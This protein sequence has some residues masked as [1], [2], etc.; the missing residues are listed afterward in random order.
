MSQRRYRAR[1]L[2][3]SYSRISLHPLRTRTVPSINDSHRDKV[4]AE[5]AKYYQVDDRGYLVLSQW[6]PKE[7]VK[8]LEASGLDST[9]RLNAGGGMISTVLDL[10]KFDVAMDRNLIVYEASKEAMFTS[11][12]SNSGQSCLMD[13]AGSYRNMRGL[14]LSGTMAGRL[15]R[16]HT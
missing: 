3:I 9:P 4:L 1:A 14:R 15:K 8:A 11:T 5:R 13:W 16:I 2:P 7:I 6:P 10:A 12:I